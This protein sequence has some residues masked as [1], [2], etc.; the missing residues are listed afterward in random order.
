MEFL[1][2]TELVMA[3]ATGLVGLI[4]TAVSTFFAI[5]AWVKGLKDKNAQEIWSLVME[6][7][8]KAM[9]EAERSGASGADKKTMVIDTVKAAAAAAGFD[10]TAL[11]DQLST[12]IDQ[13]I[14]FFND[15][16]KA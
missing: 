15:M 9:A 6:I 5:K 8:D 16:K 12:Y 2:N 11:L 4:G 7:A 3:F 14:D 13:T 1:E 10:V